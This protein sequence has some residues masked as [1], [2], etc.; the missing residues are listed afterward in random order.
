MTYDPNNPNNLGSKNFW[1]G[2]TGRENPPAPTYRMFNGKQ[3]LGRYMDPWGCQAM[4]EWSQKTWQGLW[5]AVMLTVAMVAV[6]SFLDPVVLAV[7][8]P[9]FGAYA[10]WHKNKLSKQHEMYWQIQQEIVRTDKP[11]WVPYDSH[12][13]KGMLRNPGMQWP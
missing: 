10:W 5:Q 3:R 12:K 1:A 4:I 7:I 6:A 13:L 8:I 2:H 9:G 11:I